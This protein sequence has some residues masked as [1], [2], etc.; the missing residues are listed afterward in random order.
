MNLLEGF[1]VASLPVHS[2]EHL[3]LLLE[4]TKLAYADRDRWIAD[5]EHGHVPVERLL[6]K[7]YAQARR[8]AFDPRKRAGAHVGRRR[9]A[10]PPA[11][12]WRTGRRT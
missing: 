2:A 12:W 1:D 11:S 3:H 7:E 10:T 6:S 4:M 5:P 8:A 9:T